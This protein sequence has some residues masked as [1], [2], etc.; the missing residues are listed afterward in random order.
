VKLKQENDRKREAF[1]A[2][3]LAQLQY[4]LNKQIEEKKERQKLDLSLV[5]PKS[6]IDSDFDLKQTVCLPKV[7]RSTKPSLLSFN[8]K[9]DDSLRKVIIP[10]SLVEKF[11]LIAS[12]N[13]E[14]N[15]ETCAILCGKF[16]QNAFTITHVLVPKQRGTADS[17]LTD[18]EEEVFAVQDK[19]DLITV[20]WIHTHPTQSSF[21]SSIDLHTHC[22]YQLMLPGMRLVNRVNIILLQFNFNIILIEAIAI[23]CAPKLDQMGCFSLTDSYGLQFIANCKLTSFHPH[24]KDPP[25]YQESQHISFDDTIQVNLIDLR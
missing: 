18:N 11:L 9:C 19:H 7:D 4:K 14:L 6:V 25:L 15:I 10:S 13:T 24:P 8:D 23:V 5:E 12:A 21:M 2:Q 22:S 3:R 16:T 20:G 17:C 1:E